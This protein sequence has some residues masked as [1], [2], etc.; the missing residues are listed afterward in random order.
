[1][2]QRSW[3]STTLAAVLVLVIVAG[4][5]FYW[6]LDKELSQLTRTHEE[7]LAEA[8]QRQEALIGVQAERDRLQALLNTQASEQERLRQQL[9]RARERLEQRNTSADRLEAQL[10][11]SQRN[12]T[13]ARQQIDEL[14]DQLAQSQAE[15]AGLTARRQDLEAS[16]AT[17]REEQARAR[18][19]ANE[20]EDDLE[21][22]RAE[23][24]QAR[25]QVEQRKAALDEASAERQ[26]VA[27]QYRQAREQ[28]A[29]QQARSRSASET[30]AELEARLQREQSA[31]ND[32]QTRLQALSNEKQTLVSRLEDGTTVIKLPENIVFDSGSARI[33][34]SGRQTLQLLANALESFPDH[35]ISVQGHSDSRSISPRLQYRYPTNWE[36]SA[37][38]AASAVRVLRETGIAAE[39]MQAVGY[40]NIRPLVEETDAASRR[41]NRRIEVLLYPD[42]WQVKEKSALKPD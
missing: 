16:L 30:I 20:L 1:M 26:S 34:E 25:D 36:L 38:R 18:V 28:L 37:S 14:N 12:L 41:M 40:A 9:L 27:E 3:V 13:D 24:E 29:L 33:G 15:V 6:S 31:M 17:A 4:V 8:S 5:Y 35:T 32:L 10:N 42:E 19:Q 11:D 23:L 22:A 7:T 21:T 39:R 2:A